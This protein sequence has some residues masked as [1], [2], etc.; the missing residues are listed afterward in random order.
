MNDC[1]HYQDEPL[2]LSCV[3]SQGYVE[4]ARECA[5][6]LNLDGFSI[7]E[8]IRIK[9]AEAT[10]QGYRVELFDPVKDS[11]V[12]EMLSGFDNPL[13]QREIA[14]CVAD[15][16]PVVIAA[17]E[18]KAVG[19]AGPVIRQDNGRGY[20]AGIGVLPDHEG[21]GLGSILFFQL[22][23]AFRNIRTE[24]LVYRTELPDTR[25]K[26]GGCGRL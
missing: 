2:V 8:E 21:H 13:W 4:R 25:G 16:V 23:E 15:R 18:G 20:F 1:H 26:L 19:F 24:Y 22:C 7:P 3:L 17:H 5:M 9:E 10:A 11:G 14:Q 12:D 6:Y